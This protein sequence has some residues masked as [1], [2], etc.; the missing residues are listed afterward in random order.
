MNTTPLRI[1]IADDDPLIRLDLGTMLKNLG[2]QVVGEAPDG[3]QA[4]ALARTLKPDVVIL[5]VKMPEMDGIEAAGVIASEAVAPVLLLTAYSQTDL[6]QRAREAG[7]FAYLVKP[8]KE[9]D[10]LP[11]IG[12]AVARFQHFQELEGEAAG[13]EERLETRKTVE[14]AKGVLIDLYG[15][16]EQ[17]AFRRIQTQS[18]NTRKS[19][20]EIAEAVLIAHSV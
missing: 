11:A 10:L 6:V 14:R 4:L 2:H 7:V 9:A 8:F 18:M 16:K 1:L 20:R 3:A 13:L 12:V 5:D 17:E 19:M 15:L